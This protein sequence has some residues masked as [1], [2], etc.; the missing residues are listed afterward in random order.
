MLREKAVLPAKLHQV[1]ELIDTSEESE[2]PYTLALTAR[3]EALEGEVAAALTLPDETEQLATLRRHELYAI[4]LIPVA[5]RLQDRSSLAAALRI[6]ALAGL[7]HRKWHAPR[8]EMSR[9]LRLANR[10]LRQGSAEARLPRDVF[11]LAKVE[12]MRASVLEQAFRYRSQRG[13]RAAYCLFANAE[14]QFLAVG[15]TYH[16]ALQRA[17]MAQVAFGAGTLG[18]LAAYEVAATDFAIASAATSSGVSVQQ[19]A[20]WSGFRGS[21]L[22]ALAESGRSEHFEPAETSMRDAL[23]ELDGSA[24]PR[25]V[26]MLGLS[27]GGLLMHSRRAT[28]RNDIVQ[29]IAALTSARELAQGDDALC[30][31][32]DYTLCAAYI[33]APD[34]TLTGN[35]ERAI[36]L[37]ERAYAAIDRSHTAVDKAK[38][39]ENLAVAYALRIKGDRAENFAR[40]MRLIEEA[41]SLTSRRQNPIEWSNREGN[42]GHILLFHGND[43][44]HRYVEAYLR[45]TRALRARPTNERSSGPAGILRLK[46]ALALLELHAHCANLRRGS[47]RPIQDTSAL[48]LRAA[49]RQATLAVEAFATNTDVEGRRRALVASADC[50]AAGN[51]WERALDLLEQARWLQLMGLQAPN[52]Q[53]ARDPLETFATATRSLGSYAYMHGAAAYCAIRIG[54][55]GYA[56]EL[57]ENAKANALLRALGLSHDFQS[58][59]SL[60]V[61]DGDVVALA[62][63]FHRAG[64]AVLI[65]H[66]GTGRPEIVDVVDLPG[67][68]QQV[69][70]NILH[71]GSASKAPFSQALH[72]DE[73]FAIAN[74]IEAALN[75]LWSHIV[76]P[77]VSRLDRNLGSTAARL[78]LSPHSGS[79]ALP[80]HAAGPMGPGGFP[81]TPGPLWSR[82]RLTYLPSLRLLASA[83][84]RRALS[85]KLVTIA[86]PTG[87]IDEAGTECHDIARIVGGPHA[88]FGPNCAEPEAIV[89]ACSDAGAVHFCGHASFDPFEPHTSKFNLSD[90]TELSLADISQRMKLAG[91]PLMTLA[92]CESGVADYTE[93]S[94]EFLGMPAAFLAAGAGCVVASQWKVSDQAA[95]A[96]FIQFYR[97][98]YQLQGAPADAVVAT[99]RMLSAL[100]PAEALKGGD[101]WSFDEV[102]INEAIEIS[103]NPD[104]PFSHPFYWAP[105]VVIG[106]G[107]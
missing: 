88:H 45:F 50:A 11:D 92:A 65:A 96:F 14:A 38:A 23:A 55:P 107:L 67:V 28:W 77:V 72:A 56:L 57:L 86:D 36:T 29:S 62:P 22:G 94:D 41:L 63:V 73:P 30:S 24:H 98:V 99:A 35:I 44:P 20:I 64:A 97:R 25:E 12:T 37:G 51:S 16:A 95:R 33:F 1:N 54:R 83:P 34:G 82:W 13:M 100:T 79:G 80:W 18:D 70:A 60:T 89:A 101:G 59:P 42:A 43:D 15:D 103:M 85:A 90:T 78:V 6:S 27:L 58:P 48:L 2:S 66:I 68:T 87:N 40:A 106:R 46:A 84:R 26:A 7:Y 74:A 3:L 19:R 69:L 9:R 75:W 4:A 81:T 17:N 61:P 105:F 39:A 104:R 91:K 53:S 47:K 32:I 52:P 102:T 71:L 49:E 31:A 21:A 5:M 8:A 93:R 76:E 10:L